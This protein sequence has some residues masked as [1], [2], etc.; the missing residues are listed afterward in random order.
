MAQAM[1]IR[2]LVMEMLLE[3]DQQHTYSHIL[4]RD[5]QNKYN[6]LS[7]QEKSFLKRLF[8]GTLERRIE[9][10]YVLNQF[11]KVKV[12]KMKPVIRTIMRMSTYQILFMDSVPDSAACNEAVKLAQKKSFG[13]L[14]GFVNG[15]LRNVARGK[16]TIMYPKREED[17]TAYLS[18]TYSMPEWII[19]MWIQQL[20]EETAETVVKNLLEEHSVV[21]RLTVEGQEQ[22]TLLKAI[23]AQGTRLEQ[24]P[25]LPYAYTI[26][27]TEESIADIPGFQ[28][29]RMIVQDVSSMLA[30][31]AAGIQPGDT[32]LDVCAAPGGKSM[33]A[34]LKCG[35][36]GEIIAHD[37][38]DVKVELIRENFERCHIGNGTASVWDATVKDESMLGKADVVIADLPCSGLGVIGKK[39]DI[40]YRVSEQ[41]LK[42]VETLQKQILSVITE[43]VKP[44]GVLLFSTCTI[45]MAENEQ[46]ME[47][48]AKEYSFILESLNPFLPEMLHSK[49]TNKGYLQLLPGVH[50]TDGFFMAR[51]RRK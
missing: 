12:N 41:S 34:S 14:K 6:Y 29:G 25:Y 26:E 9:L 46:M 44:G 15:V 35:A 10:D 17:L 39:R 11:S 42:E 13:S 37:L 32:V 31:E 2:Q 33:L 21:V 48:I 51:L 5:V 23:E 28:D 4:V 40:K 24:H 3:V 38:T 1:N 20:G 50:Q 19:S 27:A 47:W 16:D 22:Q 43:Y 7:A 49:S 36:E 8:E 45:N 30:V 18:V